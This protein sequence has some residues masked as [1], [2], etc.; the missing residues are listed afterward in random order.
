MSDYIERE[1]VIAEFKRMKLG[2]N[3][4]VEKLFSDG[5]YS[6]LT[7]FTA[8]DVVEARRG[9]WEKTNMNGFLRCSACRDCYIDDNWLDG[10]HWNFCPHCGADLRGEEN[11]EK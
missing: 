7:T 4:L 9:T 8:A 3:S 11:G 1:A 6:V 10:K 5:V 2:E